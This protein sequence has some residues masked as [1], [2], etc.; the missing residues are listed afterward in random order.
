D[1]NAAKGH[2]LYEYAPEERLRKAV[3][4]RVLAGESVDLPNMT[5][6]DSISKQMRYYDVYYR[7]VRDA[8]GGVTGVVGVVVD[9]SGSH[10]L[11]RQKDEFMALAS[12][13]LRTPVTSILGFAQLSLRAAER[14]GD[15][16]LT[17]SLTVIR[18]QAT[19]L[20]RIVNDLLDVSRI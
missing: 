20:S 15:E 18:D 10:E 6:E 1:L 12:H 17:R 11:E 4:R 3:H 16:R 19:H 8:V 5:Y 2:L 9:V 7:P 13:E 14:S